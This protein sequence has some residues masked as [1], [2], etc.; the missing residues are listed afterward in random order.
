[1]RPEYLWEDKGETG[2][3][4]LRPPEHGGK[5]TGTSIDLRNGSLK[6]EKN[7]RWGRIC[8]V[9]VWESQGNR[10]LTEGL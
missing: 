2:P 6:L 7:G 10:K 1:M 4:T 8:T 9:S 3:G 5:G